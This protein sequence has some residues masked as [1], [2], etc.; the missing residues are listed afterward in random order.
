MYVHT[1]LV[2]RYSKMISTVRR[3]FIL[4]THTKWITDCIFLI[5][6]ESL[7]REACLQYCQYRVMKSPEQK[8]VLIGYAVAPCSRYN[9]YLH[10]GLQHHGFATEFL[11]LVHPDTGGCR[12]AQERHISCIKETDLRHLIFVFPCGFSMAIHLTPY[13]GFY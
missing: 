9:I 2:T 1:E 7:D 11:Y 13:W 8:T 6:S 3:N 4:S 5:L 12:I 10:R